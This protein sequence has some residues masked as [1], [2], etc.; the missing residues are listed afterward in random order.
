MMP[1][2]M[3]VGPKL[4]KTTLRMHLCSTTLPATLALALPTLAPRLIGRHLLSCQAAEKNNRCGGG[5]ASG[6][7]AESWTGW[8]AARNVQKPEMHVLAPTNVS[9]STNNELVFG[10]NRTCFLG[11]HG[12]CL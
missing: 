9:L 8:L 5:G 4:G 3:A 12:A 2:G 10:L 1:Q 6:G 11:R 7:Q